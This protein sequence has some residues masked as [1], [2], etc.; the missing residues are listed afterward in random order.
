MDSKI[1]KIIRLDEQ[2]DSMALQGTSAYQFGTKQEL[3]VVDKKILE[4]Y[5]EMVDT[6]IEVLKERNT[7]DIKVIDDI[8]KEYSS[9]A[10]EMLD[11]YIELLQ[12]YSEFNNWIIKKEIEALNKIDN[13]I[14]LGKEIK[15]T[16][17]VELADCYFRS[18]K[19]EKARKIL[20]D[21]LKENPDEDE[22]YMCMQ[23]WYI[24][25]KPNYDKLA[26]VIDLAE[27]NNHTLVTDFGYDE[28]IKYYGEIGDIKKK[29]KYEELYKKW[30]EKM[31]TMEI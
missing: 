17:L 2:I 12:Y 21:Y 13:N 6:M 10:S 7:K 15:Q 27:T 19:E 28:L 3:S 5:Q 9:S 18:G 23:N 16:I 22:P 25:Y 31:R 20:L 8:L 14:E 11:D 1:E 26:E 24:Y 29:E 4:Y 30:Q